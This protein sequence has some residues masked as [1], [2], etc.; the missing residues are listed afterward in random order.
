MN[1]IIIYSTV[2]LIL[3]LLSRWRISQ[4]FYYP[5][6]ISYATPTEHGLRYEEVSFFSQDGTRLSGWFLP[7]IGTARGTV[8]HFHGNAEN[9]TSHFEFVDWLPAAGYNLLVFDYRGYGKSAGRP[10][11]PGLYEDSQAALAYLRSRKDIDPNKLLLL[12]Q[13]LGGAQAIA[14]VGGGDRQGV[15]AVVVDSTFYSYRTIV[16]DSIAR[17][18]LFSLFKTPLS[19]ILISDDLS[20]ADYIG[21]IA[22]IPLL[23]IHGTAD[24]VIPYRHAEL[25]LTQAKEPKSFWRLEGSDH[26]AAFI[27]PDSPYR[28]Q[29]LEFFAAALR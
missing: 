21:R 4:M 11:R 2:L 8:L 24:E 14:V 3:F 12:G 27:D 16:R 18:P 20:P 5:D 23:L 29:L 15:R 22:P 10:D 13:S 19:R 17:M 25:L 9:M 28:R 26:T 7:A 1:R 6:R